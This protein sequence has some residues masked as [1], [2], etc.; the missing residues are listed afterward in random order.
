MCTDERKIL[1][2]NFILI[3]CHILITDSNYI[4]IQYHKRL[5]RIHGIS[6]RVHEPSN[7]IHEPSKR[8]HETFKRKHLLKVGQS[9]SMSLRYEEK[10]I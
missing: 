1:V 5:K 8:A 6:K 7:R 10:A 4:H 3:G 2:Q 9:L